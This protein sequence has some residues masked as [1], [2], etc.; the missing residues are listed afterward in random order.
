M[1]VTLQLA[2][3]KTRTVRVR[4][5][6]ILSVFSDV[7]SGK[8]HNTS[9]AQNVGHLSVLLQL[10]S[11]HL[12][13]PTDGRLQRPQ[14]PPPDPE[15][16]HL[17]GILQIR[18]SVPS[19][20][21][22]FYNTSLA[23]NK[24]NLHVFYIETDVHVRNW[25]SIII[26]NCKKPLETVVYNSNCLTAPFLRKYFIWCRGIRSSGESDTTLAPLVEHRKH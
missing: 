10:H 5:L 23:N 6:M 9:A 17:R 22:H 13:Q 7:T 1:K 25:V 19:S 15:H 11:A 18:R 2:G 26:F 3:V 16:R 12:S 14:Q 24:T 20:I 21:H 8:W 4:M